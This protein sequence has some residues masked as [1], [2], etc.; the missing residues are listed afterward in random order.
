MADTRLLFSSLLERYPEMDIHLDP[1]STIVHSPT[2]EKAAIK[3]ISGALLTPAEAKSG[4]RTYRRS[5]VAT[6]L[7][8]ACDH[9]ELEAVQELIAKGA[10]INVQD[11]Q[12][13][14]SLL[15]AAESGQTGVVSLSLELSKKESKT[16]LMRATTNDH[17]DVVAI[18]LN[19]GNHIDSQH[20]LGDTA[21]N[22]AVIA[23]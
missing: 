22:V 15:H 20:G 16:P 3:A 7:L 23:P 6:A 9:G 14:S 10:Y 12:G 1:A 11:P 5:G 21:L 4:A 17:A 2:F 18:L 13:N 8:A 19:A